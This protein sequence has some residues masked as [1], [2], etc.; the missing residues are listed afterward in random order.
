MKLDKFDNCYI[1][2]E[3]IEELKNIYKL[4]NGFHIYYTYEAVKEVILSDMNGFQQNVNRVK[5]FIDIR[6]NII[7]FAKYAI[8]GHPILKF[9]DLKDL[10]M[11]TI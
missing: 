8:T 2:I 4:A 7:D 11:L 3:N 10:T 6:R 5:A 1:I 9:K